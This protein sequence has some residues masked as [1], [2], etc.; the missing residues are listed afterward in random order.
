MA[1]GRCGR[2]GLVVAISIDA[3]QYEH[4]PG[5]QWQGANGTL[6]IDRP[7]GVCITRKL[8]EFLLTGLPTRPVPAGEHRIDGNAMQPGGE[9]AAPLKSGQ[10]APGGHE[11]FLRTV[12]SE[13][14]L[15]GQPQAQA[16]H[17]TRVHPV[18]LLEGASISAARPG[19]EPGFSVEACGRLGNRSKLHGGHRA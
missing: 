6:D 4:V 18:N 1:R 19:D 10:S 12:L 7:R 16:V 5:A 15:P 2:C 8:E 11:G 14:P 13:F 9:F 3:D 17:P